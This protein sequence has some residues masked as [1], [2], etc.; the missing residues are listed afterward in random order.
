LIIP[1]QRQKAEPERREEGRRREETEANTSGGK[2]GNREYKLPNY[3][4]SY[5]M[6]KLLYPTHYTFD[7]K[8]IQITRPNPRPIG[9]DTAPHREPVGQPTKAGRG[10]S[11]GTRTTG[12]NYAL[13]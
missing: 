1:F 10:H 5:S 13:W 12:V 11:E 4:H 3:T 9:T 7:K 8:T 6:A 2:K